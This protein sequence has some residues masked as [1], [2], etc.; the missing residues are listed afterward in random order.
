MTN[1]DG[2]AEPETAVWVRCVTFEEQRISQVVGFERD[3][4]GQLVS[5]G[6]VVKEPP[7]PNDF[8]AMDAI[9]GGGLAVNVVWDNYSGEPGDPVGQRRTFAFRDGA[10][11]QIGGPAEFKRA[12]AD[13]KL[14][15]VGDLIWPKAGQS[16]AKL[17]LRVENKGPEDAPQFEI[18]FA[19][20]GLINV[21]GE[22]GDARVLTQPGLKTGQTL[23]LKLTLTLDPS[24][25]PANSNVQ[26]FSFIIDGT[27]D[28]TASIPVVRQ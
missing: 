27:N 12:K 7:P 18:M 11:R 10:F 5:L 28:N 13:L 21:V 17:T 6:A 26:V 2:D 16:T 24:Q 19:L 8:T 15:V 3:A 14:T 25:D 23:E 20:G 22:G 1:L 4:A 9:A